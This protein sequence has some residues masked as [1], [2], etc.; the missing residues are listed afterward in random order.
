MKCIVISCAYSFGKVL[1]LYCSIVKLGLLLR[2]YFYYLPQAISKSD[3][4]SIIQEDTSVILGEEPGCK[5]LENV[6][7]YE[8]IWMTASTDWSVLM[9]HLG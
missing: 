6:T 7:K 8:S 2:H 3:S 4:N 5:S 1:C 9:V